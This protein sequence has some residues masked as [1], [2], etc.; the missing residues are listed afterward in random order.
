MIPCLFFCRCRVGR[1]S[2]LW[3]E[4]DEAGPR[5]YKFTPLQLPSLFRFLQSLRRILA[6][7]S[8]SATWTLS[9]S[10]GRKKTALPSE[11]SALS[12]SS[13]ESFSGLP[14][15]PSFPPCVCLCVRAWACVSYGGLLC[16]L[17]GRRLL[18]G[19]RTSAFQ[20]N[21]GKLFRLALDLCCVSRFL[22]LLYPVGES[23]CFP[24]WLGSMQNPPRRDDNVGSNVVSTTQGKCFSKPF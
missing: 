7:F 8:E 21:Q 22:W 2:S 24:S 6:Y 23:W 16:F 19:A 3:P 11:L 12:S 18:G 5:A 1:C 13:L 17:Q 14:L 15:S 10:T 4:H 20:R 9:V